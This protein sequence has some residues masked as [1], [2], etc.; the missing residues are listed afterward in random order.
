MVI[1]KLNKGKTFQ[2]ILNNYTTNQYFSISSSINSEI[3]K[4]VK[5]LALSQPNIGFSLILKRGIINVLKSLP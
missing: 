2:F 5:L 3:I 4:L 1:G